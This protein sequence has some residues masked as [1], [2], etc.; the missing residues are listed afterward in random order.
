MSRVRGSSS[1][2]PRRNCFPPGRTRG[3]RDAHLA[4]SAASFASR[5]LRDL[6]SSLSAR[7]SMA[8][9]ALSSSYDAIAPV[10]HARAFESEPRELSRRE[11]RPL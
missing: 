10:G 3:I 4:T 2:V 7:L 5:A 6:D 8:T 9:R 11:F 1:W